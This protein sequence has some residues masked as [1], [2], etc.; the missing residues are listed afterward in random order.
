MMAQKTCKILFGMYLLFAIS[1]NSI[2]AQEMPFVPAQHEVGIFGKCGPRGCRPQPNQGCKPQAQANQHRSVLATR[3]HFAGTT[4][5]GWATAISFNEKFYIVSCAHTWYP[6]G[7]HH[8]LY[9]GKKLS[10]EFLGT[11]L[12]DD[13]VILKCPVNLPAMDLNLDIPSNGDALK[14]GYRH[15]VHRGFE[16]NDIVVKGYVRD[17]DSGGPIYNANGLVGII[18]TYI[19]PTLKPLGGDTSGPCATRI[20]NFILSLTGSP[21]PSDPEPDTDLLGRISKLE[22]ALANLSD[23][24]DGQDGADGDCEISNKNIIANKERIDELEQR[25]KDIVLGVQRN[26]G[27]IEISQEAI[28]VHQGRL[29]VLEQKGKDSIL[30]IQRIEGTL[31]MH[32]KV[33]ES[34]QQ[35]LKGKVQFRLRIDQS[36]RVIGVDPR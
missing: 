21:S 11:S 24:A 6:N 35:T 14:L 31:S 29:D 3:S 25:I 2:M 33:I 7:E 28:L 30:R 17:G 34:N 10:V 18:A 13:L 1:I 32:S 5:H 36:G 9:N 27:A 22:D 4:K 19:H 26:A 15:G 20:A 16:G 23:G 8:F 12:A